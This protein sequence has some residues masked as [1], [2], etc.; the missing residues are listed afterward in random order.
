MIETICSSL[1]GPLGGLLRVVAT[2]RPE[3]LHAALPRL[4]LG[5]LAERAGPAG[6]ASI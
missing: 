2:A 5:H 1:E 3:R 6:L 4:G